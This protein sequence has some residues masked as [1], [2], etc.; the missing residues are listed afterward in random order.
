[1]QL[2]LSRE[3]WSHIYE[4]DPSKREKH[5]RVLDELRSVMY[6]FQR[7]VICDNPYRFARRH[8]KVELQML[9]KYLHLKTGP[10]TTKQELTLLIHSFLHCVVPGSVETMD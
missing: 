6:L 7:Y 5:A 2:F 4:F 1:M 3:L 10:H 8:T 9:A